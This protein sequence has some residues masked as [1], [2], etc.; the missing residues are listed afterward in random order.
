MKPIIKVR[1]PDGQ[2]KGIPALIGESPKLRIGDVETVPWDSEASAELRG[3]GLEYELDLFLPQ[4]RPGEGDK[5]FVFTQAVASDVWLIKHNLNKCPSVSVVDT[6]G[7][8][9]YGDVEYIDENNVRC[10]FMSAFSGK[11]YLN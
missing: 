6:G 11:A 8:I 9:V 2:W 5:S 1:G 7:N 3:E 4:G 10:R